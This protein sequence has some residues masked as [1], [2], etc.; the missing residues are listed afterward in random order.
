MVGGVEL[1]W[2]QHHVAIGQKGIELLVREKS[3]FDHA[4]KSTAT[5]RGV[6]TARPMD[7]L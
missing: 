5:G 2:P 6:Q 4:L 7:R 1:G 3:G